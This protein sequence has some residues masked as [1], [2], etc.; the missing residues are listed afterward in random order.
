MFITQIVELNEEV[1]Q[2]EGS[3]TILFWTPF[4]WDKTWS[5]LLVQNYSCG[6]Y[7]TTDRK[8]LKHSQLVVFHWRDISIHDLPV[9][10]KNQKWVWFLLESPEYTHK[11]G[12]LKSF[13]KYI[14]CS[15]TYR[16]DSDFYHAYGCSSNLLPVKKYR[17]KSNPCT[18][19]RPVAWLVSACR[20]ASQREK[21]VEELKKFIDVDIYGKCGLNCDDKQISCHQYLQDNYMFYLSFENSMCKD[22]LTEKIYK[23]FPLNMIPVVLGGGDY[24]RLFPNNSVINAAKFKSPK[25]LAY[26]LHKVYEDEDLCSSYFSWKSDYVRNVSACPDT[27][28]SFCKAIQ[29][30][31]ECKSFN[32]NL[33]KWWYNNADCKTWQQVIK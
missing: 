21:Y 31:R 23:M 17:I 19:R 20:T 24:E 2:Y 28:C 27:A 10:Y 30:N 12:L 16:S 26:Y 6:C 1:T 18:K 14:D 32:G 5:G 7:L 13:Q 9:K 15:A 33:I 22:Y 8:M 25:L 3:N 29:S 4:F 11:K